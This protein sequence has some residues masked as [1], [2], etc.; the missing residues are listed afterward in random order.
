V[1]LAHGKVREVSVIGMSSA[2]RAASAM[3]VGSS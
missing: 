2:R 3:L 1:L